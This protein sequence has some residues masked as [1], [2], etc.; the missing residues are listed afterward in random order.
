MRVDEIRNLQWPQ[1]DFL[2]GLIRL[3]PGETKNNEGRIGR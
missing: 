1:I 2:N 3:D